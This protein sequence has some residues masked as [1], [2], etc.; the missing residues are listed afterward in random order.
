MGRTA[1]NG[2]IKAVLVATPSNGRNGTVQNACLINF[3][4]HAM[5]STIIQL[6]IA[7]IQQFNYC[8]WSCCL[9][10]RFFVLLVLTNYN[11]VMVPLYL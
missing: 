3:Y 7:G 4:G 9:I 5:R 1:G 8:T 2:F 6:C 11:V 10:M